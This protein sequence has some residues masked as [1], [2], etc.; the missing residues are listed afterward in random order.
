M[1]LFSPFSRPVGIAMTVFFIRALA[2]KNISAFA[3]RAHLSGGL[4]LI[5]HL[6]FLRLLASLR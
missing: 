1:T 3:D 4:Y 6:N 2:V 5:I